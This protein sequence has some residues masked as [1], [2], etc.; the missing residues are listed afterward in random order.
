MTVYLDNAASTQLSQEVIKTMDDCTPY[1]GNP[2][3][4]HELGQQSREL[5]ENSRRIIADSIN[6]KSEEIIFT[7]GGTESNNAALLGFMELNNDLGNHIITTKIEHDSVLNTCKYLQSVG[8]KITYLD[9]NSQ[10]LIDLKQ[11][12]NSIRQN[13]ILVSI[14][15]ANNE[16][17][18]VQPIREIAKICDKYGV[19]FHTDGVQA[20]GHLNID[21]NLLGIYMLSLSGHKVHAPKGTGILYVKDNIDFV[22]IIH[23]GGQEFGLRSGTENT[24]G[25]TALGK[26]F[27]ELD[28]TNNHI[29]KLHILLKQGILANID[30]VKINECE[31]SGL[32][33]ILNVSFK[34]VDGYML[35]KMLSDNG[36]YVS[37]GSA[38]NSKDLKP[39][40]V[41]M[42]L[43]LSEKT[44]YNSIRF[45]FSKYNT[46]KEIEY[47]LEVLPKLVDNIRKAD[48]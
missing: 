15:F 30:G 34:N 40:H 23:G 21:V 12:E 2:S 44:A 9:V 47:I 11:L 32:K 16:I 39:S 29:E 10:G 41:L 25:I 28:Y 33:N 46:E 38:C 22:P 26:A 48:L 8:Y 24:A 36:I 5:I 43:G 3:S 20:I 45:S 7:S 42:A 35:A 18:T 1:Y 13:T 14:I 37:N 17:G 6:A 19:C 4:I 31:Y 27:E